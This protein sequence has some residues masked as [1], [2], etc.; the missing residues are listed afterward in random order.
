ML[1]RCSRRGE[2]VLG[3]ILGDG[4]YSGFVGIDPKRSGAHYGSHPQL[5][6][7]LNIA[8]ED[9]TTYSVATDE[10]WQ[11]TIGP[12][13]FSDLLMGETYDARREIENWDQPNFDDAEWQ[14][15]SVEEI[16]DMQLVAEPSQPVRVT[17]EIDAKK[18]TEPKEGVYVFDMGQNMVGWAQLRVRGEAGT[19]VT[20]RYAEALNPRWDDLYGEPQNRPAN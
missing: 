12:I 13:A 1:R 17:Q 6:A 14:P 19:Q 10:S 9:G 4:W 5:L 16:G 11:S 7:Q 20:L 2:N 3:A 8:Y 18:V 15:V